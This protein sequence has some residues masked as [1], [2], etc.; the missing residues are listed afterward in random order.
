MSYNN[1]QNFKLELKKVEDWLSKEYSSVHTGR[2]TPMI[3]DSLMVDSYGSK[4]PIK[5]VAQISI[6]DPKTLRVIPW[7]KSQIKGIESAISSSNLGLSVVSDGEGVRVI[8]PM[9]TTEN[10]S[11]L[12]KVLKE[13]LE[14]ARI[15]VRKGRQ[16]EMDKIVDLSEDDKNRAKDEIQKCVDES[17][18][19]L[20]DIFLKKEKDLMNN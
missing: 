4:M 11:K 18:R 12:V 7:D 14:E 2:A 20:E 19:N 17:N 5:N 9:L 8:F 10:R 6:E 16:D 13:K 15:S 3:L 1:T